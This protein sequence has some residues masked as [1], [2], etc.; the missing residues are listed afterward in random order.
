MK[1][2]VVCGSLKNEEEFDWKV[3]G[4][5]R[6]STCK[7]CSRVRW[8][9]WY[10]KNKDSRS[11]ISLATRKERRVKLRRINAGLLLRYIQN[12]PCVDCGE[13]D[14]RVLEFDH[15]RD[16]KY[17]ISEMISNFK[18]ESIEREIE[19][20]V[21]R[22]ANCHRRRHAIELNWFADIDQPTV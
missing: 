7:L 11:S 19:K 1:A 17:C 8:N 22:C 12:H 6:Q 14:W 20:C 3:S 13:T 9:A 18:W 16:K 15:L 4:R 10:A 5:T 21:V 2:C